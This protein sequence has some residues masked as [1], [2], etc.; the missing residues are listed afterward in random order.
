MAFTA[1]QLAGNCAFLTSIRFL[2]GQTRG[3]FDA[4]P[5][6]A[7]LL[8]SHQRWLLTQTAYA[9]HLEYD[10]RDPTSGLTAVGLTGRIT[11]HK[12][13]SRNTVLAFIEELFTYRFITHTPGD[14]RRRPRHF[15]PANVS[16]QAM[17]AW[18]HANLAA[19]DLLDGGERAAVFQANPSLMRLVQP[20]IARHCLE[21][22]AWREPPAQVALF[23][24]TEAG[25]LVVDN[26]IA[27]METEDAEAGKFLVGRVETRALAADFMMSRT[28]LQRLLAKAAQRG[29]VGWYDEPRKAHLWL[30][31]HFVEEYCAWQAVKFAYVDEAF[32]WA[33]ARIDPLT[34]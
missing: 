22:A 17:S 23:L 11:A 32:E 16:L 14:E 3:M 18:I 26:F 27:R 5:R 25:G 29:C 10:P 8:A 20:R 24:W 6:L 34:V 9:L 31:R 4:G 2:A 12:V 13:A 15:E 30:S 33:T 19:L 1:E 28:H 7:R 21:D